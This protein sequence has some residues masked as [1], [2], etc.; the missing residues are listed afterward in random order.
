MGLVFW[1][2]GWEIPAVPM[3]WLKTLKII[4]S[5]ATWLFTFW[6][7][8]SGDS[9]H[10]QVLNRWR[11][12]MCTKHAPPEGKAFLQLPWGSCFF[13]RAVFPYSHNWGWRKGREREGSWVTAWVLP[14]FHWIP[15]KAWCVCVRA[16]VYVCVCVSEE[17]LDGW[18]V[19]GL[20]R[21]KGNCSLGPLYLSRELEQHTHPILAPLLVWLISSTQR[22][23]KDSLDKALTF[24]AK[25]AGYSP[26]SE[27][28]WGQTPKPV[29]RQ[30]SLTT[31]SRSSLSFISVLWLIQCLRCKKESKSFGNKNKQTQPWTE[32][33]CFFF[34]PKALQAQT[35]PW[36]R[37]PGGPSMTEHRQI[38]FIQYLWANFAWQYWHVWQRR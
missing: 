29:L 23:N 19:W 34:C 25:E 22:R 6:T 13:K 11:K 30:N 37:G 26:D 9:K 24:T 21:Q 5:L 32:I 8:H 16:R 10:R 28:L 33:S 35:E 36:G 12:W 31:S 7:T 3:H 27:K 17:S 4:L 18:A 1:C 2:L 15:K 14:F 38:H 20:I